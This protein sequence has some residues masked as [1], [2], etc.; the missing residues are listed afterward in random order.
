MPKRNVPEMTVTTSHTECACGATLY[1]F[2][3]L[4]RSTN[5]PSLLGSPKSTAACAPAGST[6]GAGPHLTSCGE[7]ILCASD[8]S[9]VTVDVAPA[10]TITPATRSE[11]TSFITTSDEMALRQL[12]EPTTYMGSVILGS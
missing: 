4:S 2:G 8:D 9:A 1:P 10:M 12:L 6:S 3:N 11:D 7:T 5:K